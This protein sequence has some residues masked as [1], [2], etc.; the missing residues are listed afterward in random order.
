ME[1]VGASTVKALRFLAMLRDGSDLEASLA[2]CAPPAARTFV[3]Q[4][5][6]LVAQGTTVEVLSAFLFGREDLIPEMFSRLRPQWVESA[7]AT[8][9][10]YYVTRHIELDGDAHGPAGLRAVAE[11]GGG[12]RACMGGGPLRRRVSDRRAHCVVGQGAR[13]GAT[14]RLTARLR[15]ESSALHLQDIRRCR[16]V[17]SVAVHSPGCLQAGIRPW[18]IDVGSPAQDG[19]R[20][21][22]RST[23]H[24][25]ERPLP[26]T[27]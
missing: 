3:N 27:S 20:S 5:L 4:T 10:S 11:A 16:N 24:L 18:P 8:R 14:D 15:G 17:E 19:Q 26:F 1:E 9:F 2:A 6:S 13:R 21:D 25:G 12:R 22:E 23:G 7:Q